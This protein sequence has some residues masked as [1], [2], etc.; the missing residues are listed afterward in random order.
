VDWDI[1]NQKFTN[2]IYIDVSE[3]DIPEDIHASAYLYTHGKSK[4]GSSLGN[5]NS[6]IITIVHSRIHALLCFVIQFCSIKPTNECFDFDQSNMNTMFISSAQKAA[7]FLIS[8]IFIFS[9]RHSKKIQEGWQ[10]ETAS[11]QE[12]F[13]TFVWENCKY[14]TCHVIDSMDTV[15][16]LSWAEWF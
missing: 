9:F 16:Q 1:L 11:I 6:I 12:T 3:K 7:S 13:G 5:V 8:L 15:I 2:T 14:A 4:N 10:R